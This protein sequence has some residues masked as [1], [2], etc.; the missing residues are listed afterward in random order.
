MC[1]YVHLQQAGYCNSSCATQRHKMLQGN[2]EGRIFGTSARCRHVSNV[3]ELHMHPAT[4][5][6]SLNVLFHVDS[7]LEPRS[8]FL[9]T[10]TTYELGW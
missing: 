3:R 4:S 6:N 10:G 7:R 9:R 5:A 8:L 2:K 1:T